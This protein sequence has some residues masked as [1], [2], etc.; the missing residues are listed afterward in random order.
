MGSVLITDRTDHDECILIDLSVQSIIGWVP[1]C[2]LW[3]PLYNVYMNTTLTRISTS[4]KSYR[5]L[6]K[7]HL[8][9]TPLLHFNNINDFAD[10]CWGGILQLTVPA[11]GVVISKANRCGKRLASSWG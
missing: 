3:I 5:C 10:I 8:A 11:I 2:Q 7:S 1:K 4:Q 9:A 6:E